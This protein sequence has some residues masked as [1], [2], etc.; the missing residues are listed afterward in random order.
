[1]L[2]LID[3]DTGYQMKERTGELFGCSPIPSAE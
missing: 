2:E 1:M 3:E